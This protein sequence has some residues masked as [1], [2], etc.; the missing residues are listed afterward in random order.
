MGLF[1]RFIN[2]DKPGD[3]DA[4]HDPEDQANDDKNQ[5]WFS[6]HIAVHPFT[7][8]VRL[9]IEGD[10]GTGQQ[11]VDRLQELFDLSQAEIDQL[12]EMW[13]SFVDAGSGDA[14]VQR[15][16]TERLQ[17]VLRAMERGI[18]QRYLP[19]TKGWLYTKLGITV[20]DDR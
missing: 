6:W 4:T 14:D 16:N 5:D 10:L 19:D 20:E 7:D 17:S 3:W 12:V 2:T 18:P 13:A 8:M 11:A 15:S 1:N 9:Y